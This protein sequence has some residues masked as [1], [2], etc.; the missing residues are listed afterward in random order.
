MHLL[1]SLG[2]IWLHVLLPQSM[3]LKFNQGWT[4]ISPQINVDASHRTVQDLCI[5][6]MFHS[7]A[8]L[9]INS[10]ICA[11]NA[12]RLSLSLIFCS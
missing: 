9:A 8:V 2:E 11:A 6:Y 1:K 10:S 5:V 4:Q 3:R 12:L 7:I